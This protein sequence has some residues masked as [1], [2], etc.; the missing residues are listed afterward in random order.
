MV[1]VSNRGCVQIFTGLVE[2]VVPHVVPD[3]EWINIFNKDF[4]LHLI[5]S[6]IAETWITRK[7]T[8]DGIVTSL[9]LFAADGTQIAQLYGQRTE[10]QPE[11]TQWREQLAA[12]ESKEVAA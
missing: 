10:G 9:E 7:P 12:L 11:Q 3:A 1:F 4:T 2:K 8:A 6:Q 5:E